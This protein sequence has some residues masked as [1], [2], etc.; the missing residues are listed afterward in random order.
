MAAKCP[1]SAART[2]AVNHALMGDDGASGPWKGKAAAELGAKRP[3]CR[4]P[5]SNRQSGQSLTNF[6]QSKAL[7]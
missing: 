4:P 2:L 7:C 5:S 3:R 6:T 1:P